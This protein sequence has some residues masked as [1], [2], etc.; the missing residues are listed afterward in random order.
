MVF[1]LRGRMRNFKLATFIL[2]V[3]C[4]ANNGVNG[5]NGIN[6]INGANGID[7]LNGKNGQSI[8]Y[9]QI[10]ATTEQCPTG[11]KALVIATDSEGTGVYSAVDTNQQSMVICN[12]LQGAEGQQGPVSAFSPM[13][14][15]RPCGAAS[16]PYKEVLLCLADGSV[17]SSFSSTMSG[18]NTRLAFL[19]S[20]SFQDTDESG[21]IFNV[22]TD[23]NSTTIEWSAG[24]NQYGSWNAQT[25]ICAKQ[26]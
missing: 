7:G 2:M 4:G 17:L 23:Q 24:S 18:D 3:G 11:G 9:T 22:T 20:G 15:I 25:V 19:T 16:S 8:V 21:C 13:I 6:G 10:E 12:G 1:A 14:P 26:P 5:I